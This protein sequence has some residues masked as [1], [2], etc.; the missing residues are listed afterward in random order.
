[1]KCR[2]SIRSNPRSFFRCPARLPARCRFAGRAAP[3]RPSR[4]AAS[5]IETQDAALAA[6]IEV[7]GHNVADLDRRVNQVDVAIEE[8]A[9]RGRTTTALAAVETQRKNRETLTGQRQR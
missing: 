4:A 8:A 6:R 9:K 5:A 7:A 3:N 2:R 1:M